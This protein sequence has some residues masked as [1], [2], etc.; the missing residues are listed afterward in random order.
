MGNYSAPLSPVDIQ[1]PPRN[2][3][4]E[5]LSEIEDRMETKEIGRGRYINDRKGITPNGAYKS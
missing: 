3:Q 5:V 4:S 1:K 2:F